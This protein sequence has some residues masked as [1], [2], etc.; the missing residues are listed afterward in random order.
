MTRDSSGLR[1][2]VA[3]VEVEVRATN[4]T[5]GDA[6][7]DPALTKWGRVGLDDLEPS[8]GP[9]RLPHPPILPARSARMSWAT[10][11]ACDGGGY[12]PALSSWSM[13]LLNASNG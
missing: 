4:A 3:A 1:G 5:G 11:G 7:S 10:G 12:E 13:T 9:P 2:K 6:D 8:L